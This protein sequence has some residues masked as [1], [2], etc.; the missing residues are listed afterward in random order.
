MQ[1]KTQQP[2]QNARLTARSGRADV[3]AE[4]DHKALA[5]LAKA[6]CGVRGDGA[7][8]DAVCRPSPP[9][10][11]PRSIASCCYLPVTQLRQHL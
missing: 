11:K 10:A 9:H 8:R 1:S 5:A 3:Q 6:T 4:N 7:P 2:K